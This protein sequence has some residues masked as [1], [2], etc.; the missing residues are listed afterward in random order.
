MPEPR[1][2]Y[3]AELVDPTTG[4]A[5][6]LVASTD[7]ELDQLVREHLEAVFPSP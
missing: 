6:E 3:I 7:A 4:Q 5:V 1:T 2:T